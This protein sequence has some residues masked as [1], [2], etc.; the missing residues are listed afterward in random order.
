[1]K[2]Y[3]LRITTFLVTLVISFVATMAFYSVASVFT[4][5]GEFVLKCENFCF[6]PRIKKAAGM[7]RKG[8]V[9]V[10]F[11]GFGADPKG[12]TRILNFQVINNSSE[13]VYY[14]N[15]DIDQVPDWTRI[16]GEASLPLGLCGEGTSI[17]HLHSGESLKIST[18][19][20][21]LRGENIEAG[22][23]RIGYSFRL[24]SQNQS[25][26]YWSEHIVLPDEVKDEIKPDRNLDLGESLPLNSTILPVKSS[27]LPSGSN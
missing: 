16:D 24:E 5:P 17:R 21:R 19:L 10:H 9:E 11:L 2:R 14:T 6:L 4:S 25:A 20:N 3:L 22:D 26:I 23:L 27:L 8:E 7:N 18:S 1:M 15:Y 13:S 12:G